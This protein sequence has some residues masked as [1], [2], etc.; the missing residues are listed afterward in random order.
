[1][2]VT[3][4]GQETVTI[5]G[6]VDTIESISQLKLKI[7]GLCGVPPEELRLYYRG[8][9]LLESTHKYNEL[10]KKSFYTAILMREPGNPDS[11]DIQTE[12]TLHAVTPGWD[13]S[14]LDDG[15]EF[16]FPQKR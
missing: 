8:Q 10:L 4:F 15:R 11:Y 2:H 9:E 14:M 7:Q 12:S 16:F 13:A 5:D 6:I 1:M 3:I